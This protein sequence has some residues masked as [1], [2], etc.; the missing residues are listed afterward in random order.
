MLLVTQTIVETQ[1]SYNK[2]CILE[3]LRN[4]IEI[5]PRNINSWDYSVAD[6]H[7]VAALICKSTYC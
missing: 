4:I 3:I 1:I 7:T 2:I 5:A 6:S